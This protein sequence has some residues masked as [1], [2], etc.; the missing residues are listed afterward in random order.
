MKKL[1]ILGVLIMM[2]LSCATQSAPTPTLPTRYEAVKF[3]PA[4]ERDATL[5]PIPL[6]HLKNAT[7]L[8]AAYEELLFVAN[9]QSADISEMSK[10]RVLAY[11]E[12][13]K[14][15][16]YILLGTLGGALL[17]AIVGALVW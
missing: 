17:G 12:R 14:L 6:G 16:N 15:K 2:L 9:Q 3:P 4:E 13:E 10:E 11:Y 7:I 5:V 1:L 8:A